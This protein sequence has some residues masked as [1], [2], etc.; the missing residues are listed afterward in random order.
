MDIR[1]I[2]LDNRALKLLSLALAVTLWFYVTSKG[3]TELALTI[4]LELRN[5]PQGM[6]VV[7]DVRENIEVRLQGQERALRDT[8]IRNRIAGVVDLSAAV[9]GENTVRLSPDD[10]RRPSG[11]AVTAITPYELTVRLDRVVQRTFRLRPRLR[12]VPAPGFV[13]ALVDATPPRITV[14][15]PE[16]V[17]KTLES[18]TT[19]P[20]DIEGAS[21]TFTVQPRIDYQ[22]RPVRIIEKDVTVRIYVEK[23]V[24]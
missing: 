18:L 23:V 9:P 1:T 22:G 5:V 24:P 21:K 19:L 20:I 12:G 10:I 2:L 6:A 16:R 11:V 14:E 15:G 7:G 13:V 4:P 8:S 3:K 17:V